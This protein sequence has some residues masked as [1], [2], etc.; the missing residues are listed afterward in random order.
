ME[1]LIGEWFTVID[2][3]ESSAG[4]AGGLGGGLNLVGGKR[5]SVAQEIGSV[6]ISIAT[7]ETVEL[8]DG[9]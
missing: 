4:K 7:V 1:R 2:S 6:R 5:R 8:D 9:A 3:V